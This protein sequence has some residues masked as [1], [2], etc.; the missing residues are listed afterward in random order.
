MRDW[1]PRKTKLVALA[2]GLIILNVVIFIIFKT[3][4][5][6]ERHGTDGQALTFG[7]HLGE[8]LQ[9]ANLLTNAQ[10]G[11]A[12]GLLLFWGTSLSGEIERLSDELELLKRLNVEVVL[13]ANRD[14]GT[15]NPEAVAELRIVKD[16][17]GG[18]F[19]TFAVSEQ[20]GRLLLYH[21]E[22]LQTMI[23]SG[24]LPDLESVKDSLLKVGLHP[25]IKQ[26]VLHVNE[27]EL[28][29]TAKALKHFPFD[30]LIQHA[31]EIAIDLDNIP[32]ENLALHSRVGNSETG[33]LGEPILSQ[34]WAIAADSKDRVFFCDGSANQVF[35][36][37]ANGTFIGRLGGKGQGPGEYC[38][39]TEIAIHDN[40]IFIA[41]A[42]LKVHEFDLNFQFVRSYRIDSDI[43]PLTGIGCIKEILF[44]PASPIPPQRTR[45]IQMF[46]IRS[47][48]LFFINSFCDYFQ[49]KQK[50]SNQMNALMSLNQVRFATDGKRYLAFGRWPQQGFFLIDMEARVGYNY[51]LLGEKIDMIKNKS[52]SERLPD[53]VVRYFFKDLAFDVD[54]NLHVLVP[55][56][57]LRLAKGF[58]STVLYRVEPVENSKSAFGGY[59]ALAVNK[60]YV[61]LASVSEAQMVIFEQK[62]EL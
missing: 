11:T 10:Q 46:E 30:S 49:P 6:N 35:V 18:K 32:Q 44:V 1:N 54:G 23:V 4:Q 58:S 21:K 52:V 14:L 15:K 62:V 50:Y 27:T 59:D 41:D 55:G 13:V 12:Y 36:I 19:R 56:G 60:R 26:S 47:G 17:D 16:V 39:P 61:F 5:T 57:V 3:R 22:T 7:E 31:S 40:R 8:R 29:A 24:Q 2:S 9:R 48:K 45:L 28:S 51:R 25:M 53:Y 33:S 38:S 42:C 20:F 34:P 37:D 43:L